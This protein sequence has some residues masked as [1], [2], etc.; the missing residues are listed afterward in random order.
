VATGSGAGCDCV[1]NNR[2]DVPFVSSSGV[3]H[4]PLFDEIYGSSSNQVGGMI[5]AATE[6][7]L[8]KIR[9]SY[10]VDD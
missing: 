9:F 8:T 1:T 2:T 3:I 4:Y 6:N 7:G 10:F 5:I